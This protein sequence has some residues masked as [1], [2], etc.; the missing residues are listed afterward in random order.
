MTELNCYTEHK[1]IVQSERFICYHTSIEDHF[2]ITF[3]LVFIS[4]S[5]LIKKTILKSI[6][7]KDFFSQK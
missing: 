4:V 1:E 7:N 5:I 3:I 6:I 2:I